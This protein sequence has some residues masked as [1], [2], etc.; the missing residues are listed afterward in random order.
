[1]IVGIQGGL[2]SGKTLLMSR[3]LIKDALA[4][5]DV[6]ANFNL[7]HVKFTPLDI[8]MLLDNKV[9]LHNVSV[10]IDEFTVFA[11][12]RTSMS[13]TMITYFILQTRKRNVC[14]YYTTQDFGMLDK[15]IIRHT[16]MFITADKCKDDDYRVYTV[17]DARDRDAIPSVFALRI[18]NWFK[19]FDTDEIIMPLELKKK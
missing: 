7:H 17:I 2:G 19:F 3:Y 16:H 1:M 9:D 12:C 14:L 11:D 10:G 8:A 5:R 15:R 4:G 18:S 6:H 13:N